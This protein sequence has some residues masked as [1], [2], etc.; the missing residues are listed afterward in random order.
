M[1]ESF[2]CLDE[3]F[4]RR[5]LLSLDEVVE[6]TGFRRRPLLED[7]RAGRVKHSYRSGDYFFTRAQL[8]TLLAS[9]DREISRPVRRRKPNADGSKP[10]VDVDAW[11]TRKRAQ[12]ARKAG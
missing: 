8:E 7:C 2:P 5:P 10:S 1:S 6:L 3:I 9:T 11:K 4:R 12:L